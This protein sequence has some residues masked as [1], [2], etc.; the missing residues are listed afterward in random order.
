MDQEKRAQIYG[1]LQKYIHDNVLMIP[2]AVPNMTFGVR[3]YV[4]NLA[5][6]P[7]NMPNVK[8]VTFK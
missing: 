3:D 6:D 7:G 5:H 1:E 2:I 4:D 8:T